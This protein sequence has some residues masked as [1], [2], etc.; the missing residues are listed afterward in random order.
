MVFMLKTT[1]R[2]KIGQSAPGKT[3]V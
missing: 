2:H 3:V 1:R